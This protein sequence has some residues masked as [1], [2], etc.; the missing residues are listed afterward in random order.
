MAGDDQAEYLDA[1]RSVRFRLGAGATA[2]TGGTIGT[3]LPTNPPHITTAR[4]RVT[5]DATAANTT[6]V[7]QADLAYQAAT[8]NV[9][10]TYRGD[11]TST[12][13]IASRRMSGWPRRRRPTRSPPGRR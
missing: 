1:S 12:P 2:T 11:E 13:V 6:L 5:V 10:L 3:I 7:N 4:F 8:L 9:P